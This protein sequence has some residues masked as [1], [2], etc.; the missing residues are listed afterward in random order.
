MFYFYFILT[1]LK[2]LFST[3]SDEKSRSTELGK[4]LEKLNTFGHIIGLHM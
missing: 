3:E 1:C 4:V 2:N